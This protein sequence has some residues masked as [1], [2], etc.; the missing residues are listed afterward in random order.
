MKFK[1]TLIRFIILSL[2]SG[3][4]GFAPQSWAALNLPRANAA[5]LTQASSSISKSDAAD[6]AQRR[7]G[8][9]VIK[10]EKVNA[11]G[12]SVYQVKMHLDGGRIKYVKVDSQSG[13]I[14]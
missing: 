8:G 7:F 4:A 10:V 11:N 14:L 12:R 1:M 9:K 6:I 5:A 13:K 3:L 2:L